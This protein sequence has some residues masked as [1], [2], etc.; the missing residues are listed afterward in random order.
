MMGS[1]LRLGHT[2]RPSGPREYGQYGNAMTQY[3]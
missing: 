3:Q 2:A 1:K